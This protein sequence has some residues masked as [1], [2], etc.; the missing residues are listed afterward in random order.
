MPEPAAAVPPSADTGANPRRRVVTV[1]AALPELA[2]SGGCSSGGGGGGGRQV[3]LSSL[4]LTNRG[5]PIPMVWFYRRT[6]D[7]DRLLAALEATLAEYPV[8]CGRYAAASMA[9]ALPGSATAAVDL[10]NAGVPVVI[11]EAGAARQDAGAGA[12][13]DGTLGE[14]IAR[15]PPPAAMASAHETQAAAAGGPDDVT[16]AQP[17]FFPLAAHEPFIDMD[18]RSRMDPDVGSPDVPLLS[19]QITHF[20][21][22]GGTAIGMLLMHGIGDADAQICF[23]K[24]WSQAYRGLSPLDPPPCHDRGLL[25]RGGSDDDGGAEE[26][27]CGAGLSPPPGSKY[28]LLA[29][30]EVNMPAFVAVM[31]QISAAWENEVCVVP[32]S[33]ARLQQLKA[34]AMAGLAAAAAEELA[35]AAG[36]AFLSTDDVV[37]IVLLLPGV[38]LG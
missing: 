26:E 1:R 14:A 8:L 34:H 29:R 12:D 33:K 13:G 24:D 23:A 38:F 9:P 2:S 27:G 28:R 7:S 5:R 19:I 22:G 25:D 16:L 4:D 3:A 30:G 10:S 15:L 20:A 17:C 18:A 11:S 32:L 36:G 35:V 31:S 37:T 21:Q 6:L